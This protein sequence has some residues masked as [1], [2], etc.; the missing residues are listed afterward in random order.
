MSIMNDS[1]DS[2]YIRGIVTPEPIDEVT[3]HQAIGA[4]IVGG[5]VAGV[6]SG[7]K[8]HRLDKIAREEKAARL[9]RFKDAVSS[10]YNKK[11]REHERL[12]QAKRD[13]EIAKYR[14]MERD[15]NHGKTPK[16]ED[17]SLV[18]KIKKKVGINEDSSQQDGKKN[19]SVAKGI[20][21]GLLGYGS[22]KLT[23]AMVKAGTKKAADDLEMARYEHERAFGETANILSKVW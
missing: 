13:A 21:L 1:W 6:Y 18:S 5:T 4:G 17:E 15:Y 20:G 19:M 7:I 8:Q 23:K 11:A 3:A 12:E 16:E 9:S 2:Q 22:Y 10:K 14:K